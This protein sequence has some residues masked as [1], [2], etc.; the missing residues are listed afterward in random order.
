MCLDANWKSPDDA[1]AAQV[2]LGSLPVRVEDG[3]RYAPRHAFR[4][5][6]GVPGVVYDM[7]RDADGTEIGSV[8]LLLCADEGAVMHAGHMGCEIRPEHRKQ[9]HTT[10]LI[11]ALAPVLRQHG[12]EQAILGAS[13]GHQSQYQ[14]VLDAGG[15]LVGEHFADDSGECG[16]RFRLPL[17]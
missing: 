3:Y 7:T 11:R 5:Q 15:S 1:M 17:G 13:V 6:T 2:D 9:G 16:A 14:S 12:V 10:R 8:M 4:A